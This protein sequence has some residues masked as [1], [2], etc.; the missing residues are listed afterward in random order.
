[1]VLCAIGYSHNSTRSLTDLPLTND[2]LAYTSLVFVELHKGC[3][4]FC[5]SLGTG[6]SKKELLLDLACLR[7]NAIRLGKTGLYNTL[8]RNRT[9][10]WWRMW[11]LNGWVN[12]IG[13]RNIRPMFTKPSV[14]GIIGFPWSSSTGLI[15]A[16]HNKRAIMMNIELLA[17]CRPGHILCSIMCHSSRV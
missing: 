11:A 7:D 9:S 16:A 2:F 4:Y 10:M 12:I 6:K 1:M 17:T 14:S 5:K 15:V 8:E 3:L 13:T